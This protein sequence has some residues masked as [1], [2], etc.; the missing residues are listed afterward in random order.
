MIVPVAPPPLAAVLAEAADVR[1]DPFALAEMPAAVA[2]AL[3]N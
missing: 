3:V 1:V 2:P